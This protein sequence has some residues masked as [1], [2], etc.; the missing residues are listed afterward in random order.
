MKQEPETRYC[1]GIEKQDYELSLNLC[2]QVAMTVIQQLEVVREFVLRITCSH[3]AKYMDRHL[4]A[5]EEQVT[6]KIYWPIMQHIP[7]FNYHF[8]MRPFYGLPTHQLLRKKGD[9]AKVLRRDWDA[10]KHVDCHRSYDENIHR[11][12]Y[13]R[14]QHIYGLVLQSSNYLFHLCCDFHLAKM[15][16]YFENMVRI[17]DMRFLACIWGHIGHH[18]VDEYATAVRCNRVESC[19]DIL[20]E[21]QR[22]QLWEDE[23]Q[24]EEID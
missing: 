23:R 14:V 24:Q 16:K 13:D 20:T 15:T 6:S 8:D 10:M 19:V 21:A 3:H 17:I 11:V 2:C 18:L 12:C 22:A 5:M 1:K 7:N 9:S 4:Q